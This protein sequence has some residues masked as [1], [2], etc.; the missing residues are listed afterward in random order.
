VNNGIQAAAIGMKAQIDALD[1]LANNLANLNTSGYKEQKAFFTILSEASSGSPAEDDDDPSKI[2]SSS[3]QSALNLTDGSLQG[4]GRDL[5]IALVGEGF[6]VVQ[7]PQ[8]L[9]YTRNG[10]L[11]LNG[12]YDL[13]FDGKYPVLDDKGGR[14]T[15]GPG[16]INITDTGM[17]YADTRKIAQLKLVTFEQPA[18]LVREGNSLSAPPESN[19]TPKPA[20]AQVR[21]GFLEQS[22]V[23]AVAAIV[24][25]VGIMRR[26]ESVSKSVNLLINDLDA[27]SIEKLGR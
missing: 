14:I 15:V 27:K 21:Q 6:L 2:R 24:E 19:P 5:D 8:G 1:I 25:M 12:K 13:V 4:T 7:T 16:K 3:A 22:N 23:N 9:R 11:G 10:S 26:F 20:K 18:M 17:V